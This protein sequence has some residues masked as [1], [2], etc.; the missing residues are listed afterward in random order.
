[1]AEYAAGGGDLD[2]ICPV[3]R[4]AP[5][6]GR[7]FDRAGAGV[8]GGEDFVDLGPE[9]GDVAM[10]ADNRQRRACGD[11]A[12]AGNDPF[13]RA[14]PQGEGAVLRTA[15]LAHGGEARERGQA[16]ILGPQ[17][18]APFVGFDRLAPVIA[19][20]IAGQVDVQIDQPGHHRLARKVDRRRALG[21]FGPAAFDADDT[22]ALHND[23][24][25]PFE[26]GLGGI[27]D[28]PVD[29]YGLR[30]ILRSRWSRDDAGNHSQSACEFGE[31][32]HRVIPSCCDG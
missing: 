2:D 5:Y 13:F 32:G 14:A 15:R 21:R 25:R 22:S 17:D 12:R 4:R 9:A 8:A 27:D 29:Q 24:T 18:H 28:Q 16:R 31:N 30:G 23:R 7:A 3:L 6:L 26:H 19:A 20:G 10:P 11:N 1:M